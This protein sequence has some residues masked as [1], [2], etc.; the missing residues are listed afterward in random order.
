MSTTVKADNNDPT[1]T[2]AGINFKNLFI[3]ILL[4]LYFIDKLSDT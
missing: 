3:L 1:K 2:T 4:V